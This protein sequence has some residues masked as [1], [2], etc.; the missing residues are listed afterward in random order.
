MRYRR[1][2]RGFFTLVVLGLGASQAPAQTMLGASPMAMPRA[3]EPLPVNEIA[4]PERERVRQVVTQP[5]FKGKGA[6]EAF[7]GRPELYDW[8]LDHPD[9]ALTAWRR[10]GAIASEISN[11][12]NGFYSWR[13]TRG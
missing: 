6:G 12:G 9:R 1:V 8:L 11:D 13:D 5:T 3:N 2:Q 10:L 7:G 4:G